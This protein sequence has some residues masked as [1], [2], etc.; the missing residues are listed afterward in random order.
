MPAASVHLTVYRPAQTELAGAGDN[1]IF[2]VLENFFTI[3]FTAELAVNAFA[4]FFAPFFKVLP[5]RDFTVA[6]SVTICRT[7]FSRRS[8]TARP[9]SQTAPW[10]AAIS[11]DHRRATKR[12]KSLRRLCFAR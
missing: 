6:V 7:A 1:P 9:L 2:P 11:P 3:A 5:Y 12:L 8:S 10:C 4:N